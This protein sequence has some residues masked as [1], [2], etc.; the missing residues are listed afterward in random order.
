MIAPFRYGGW[1]CFLAARLRK[2]QRK[3]RKAELGASLSRTV[4][5]KCGNYSKTKE[6]SP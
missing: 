5:E 4:R 3:R 2:W 1:R 6:K